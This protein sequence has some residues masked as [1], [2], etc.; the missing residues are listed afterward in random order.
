MAAGDKWNRDETLAALALYLSLPTS[1]MDDKGPEVIELA[2]ALGRTPGS[3]ALKIFNLRANDPGRRSKGMSHSSK[4]DAEIMSEYSSDAETV[5][6]DAFIALSQFLTDSEVV[7][8]VDE[9]ADITGEEKLVLSTSRIHQAHF[10]NL[11]LESYGRRCCIS[12]IGGK[13]LE[14]LLV[15]SH[16]KPWKVSSG[17]DK[18]APE[19]G[20]LLDGFWDKAFDQGFI[21]LN[22]NYE[23]VVSR[24][25]L[26]DE[27]NKDLIWS[28]NGQ[29]ITLPLYGAPRK[30]F[31]EYHNDVIFRA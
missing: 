23:I 1:H 17:A 9:S 21:T 19:N 27:V 30:E 24:T 10:R 4:L 15:A 13:G 22:F 14:G 25:I 28:K 31:I 3:V 11:L 20:L 5:T 7:E 12:G 8:L 6:R 18:V 29:K 2:N 26:R 16:I